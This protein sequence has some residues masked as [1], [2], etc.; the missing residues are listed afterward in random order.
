MKI[1]GDIED[2][3]ILCNKV[4]FLEVYTIDFGELPTK[5]LDKFQSDIN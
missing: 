4:T 5:V 1:N 3:I 2:F